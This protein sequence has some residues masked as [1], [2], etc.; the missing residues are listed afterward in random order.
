MTDQ[1]D[2]RRLSG[3]AAFWYV[4]AALLVLTSAAGAPSPLYVL[5]QQEWG[6]SSITLT[7][8]FAIYAVALLVTLLTVGGLSDYLGRRP[9]LASSLLVDAAAMVVFLEADGVGWLIAARIVQGLATGAA[10]GVISAYLIDLQPAARPTLGAVVSSVGSTVGLGTGALGAGLLLDHAPRPT[11]LIYAGLGAALAL[12]AVLTVLLPET[13]TPAPGA[14]ASLRPR[15]AVPAGARRTFAAALPVLVATWAMGGLYLSLGPSLAAGIFGLHS[16]LAGGLVV[17]TLMGAG[18]LSTLLVQRRVPRQTMV[19]GA[20]VLASG[21]ALTLVALH[22]GST[23]LYFAGTAVAGAGFGSAFFGAFRSLATLA[24]PRERAELFAAVFVVSYLA[25]SLPAVAAG[26]V[27]SSWGLRTTAT[28]YGAV[29]VALALV[30]VAWRPDPVPP[31]A[32]DRDTDHDVDRDTDRDTDRDVGLDVGLD[33]PQPAP[34]LVA[35]AG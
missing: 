7:L 8:V 27:V 26:A 33:A 13:V 2:Q 6:F 11:T 20:A 30:A 23:P 17:S 19:A 22:A 3:T 29:V 4:A 28:A 5:Y 16:H 9:L 21:T 34:A 24:G 35:D 15:A 12:L 25:F 18:A 10:L 31:I 14:L 1:A 32:I